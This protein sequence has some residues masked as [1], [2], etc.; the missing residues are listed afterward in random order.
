M[1][2]QFGGTEVA[3]PSGGSQFGGIPVPGGG[4]QS[5]DAG[6][7]HTL[8]QDATDAPKKIMDFASGH[9]LDDTREALADFTTARRQHWQRAVDAYRSGD[10]RTAAEQGFFGGVPFLGPALGGAADEWQAGQKGQAGAHAVEILAPLLAG[11]AADALQSDT[12]AAFATGAKGALKGAGKAAVSTVDIP[13]RAHGVDLGTLP[14]PRVAVGAAAGGGA[15]SLIGLPKE[16]GAVVGGVA[17]IVKDAIQGAKAALQD[18]AAAALR[19]TV[20]NPAWR[21][22]PDVTPAPAP[23]GTPIPA[24]SLPSGRIVGGAQ[25][26]TPD[27]RS[28]LAEIKPAAPSDPAASYRFAARDAQPA[29]GNTTPRTVAD[30]GPRPTPASLPKITAQPATPASLPKITEQP[31][32]A[33]TPEEMAAPFQ[34]DES[35]AAAAEAQRAARGEAKHNG[36]RNNWATEMANRLFQDG[37]GLTPQDVQQLAPLAKDG[38]YTIDPGLDALAKAKGSGKGALPP[39]SKMSPETILRMQQ[40]LWDLWS[41]AL[42]AHA[43]PPGYS[44]FGGAH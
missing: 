37:K 41:N 7:W 15:A 13:L 14:V 19:G 22:L 28:Q 18:R 11:P 39:A 36:A 10:Y 4:N 17:P 42:P 44:G 8:F 23:E 2:S 33:P 25:N 24:T 5:Q 35:A 26:A 3:A 20:G 21:D 1:P 38:T 40:K 9:P 16:L 6:F 29:T 31:A 43:P 30:L 12:A 32:A 27:W 34:S